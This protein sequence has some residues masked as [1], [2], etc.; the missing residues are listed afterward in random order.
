MHKGSNSSTS[1]P[2][3]VFCHFDNSYHNVCE[4]SSVLNDAPDLQMWHKILGAECPTL[5]QDW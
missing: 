4:V 3:F 5:N 2:T 1:L